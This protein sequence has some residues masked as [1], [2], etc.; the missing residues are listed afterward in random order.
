MKK[1]FV[2]A[3]FLVLLLFS[4]CGGGALHLGNPDSGKAGD[5]DYPDS[6][7]KHSDLESDC[8]DSDSKYSDLDSDY[9]DSD[10]KYSDLDSDYPDSDFP[11]S[12]EP[13][14]PDYTLDADNEIPAELGVCPAGYALV[15]DGTCKPDC[16]HADYHCAEGEQCSYDIFTNTP[17]CYCK[18]GFTNI[19]ETGELDCVRYCD[20]T[21][22]FD[23]TRLFIPSSRGYDAFYIEAHG[24]CNIKTG[25]CECLDGWTT[26][27]LEED[28]R[29][30]EL[31]IFGQSCPACSK[32][33][34]T[35]ECAEGEKYC[36]GRIYTCK[37][38]HW[39]E[40]SFCEHGC[41]KETM[42][43]NSCTPGAA[44]CSGSKS[45]ECA[46]GS[47]TIKEIQCSDGCSSLTGRCIVNSFGRVCTN[48]KKC[49]NDSCDITCPTSQDAA[50]FGQDAYYADRG[51]C[52]PRSFTVK[53]LSGQKVVIDN[54]LGLMWQQDIP[55]GS[56]S[57]G[58][59]VSYCGNLSYAGYSD[60]RLPSP[61]EILTISDAG[62]YNPALDP[63]Y[64]P[65]TSTVDED[66]YFWLNK[67]YVT[68]YADNAFVFMIYR[69]NVF[70]SKPKTS[71]HNVMCVR[72]DK[73]PKPS[74][75]TQTIFG[76]AVV[77]DST[78]GL[79]W[80]KS[81]RTY[82]NW[83]AA[84]EYCEV[85]NYAGYSDWRLPN[86]DELASLLDYDTPDAP[87]SYFPGMPKNNF[88]SS[89]S[90][91]SK[92][93]YGWSVDYYTGGIFDDYSK[94]GSMRVRCVR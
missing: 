40:G 53:T 84:L 74:Y 38:G 44:T 30:F 14:A 43:C 1:V 51:F 60:W 56:Y 29:C 55:S 69:G 21:Y 77:T 27:A 36:D 52:V 63:V 87:Y 76:D 64:F 22:C 89:T 93:Y 42:E 48:Q 72:G 49:Y 91:V 92:E 13:E 24:K 78:T 50:Y 58:S 2:F 94:P 37:D 47:G 9:P 23:G 20:D 54:N 41:N 70:Y 28:M 85:L 65:D 90:N 45:L 12:P 71:G 81:Y 5:S 26:S 46:D 88:W 7:S 33:P 57:W 68:S 61:K 80:Q 62:R 17:G 10:S 4:G 3:A 39:D 31:A 32:P 67:E 75:T 8:P 86:R 79:M 18:P 16:E 6:D 66:T 34:E 15:T 35:D 59:A 11:D 19:S 83:K 25:K 82:G 73:L